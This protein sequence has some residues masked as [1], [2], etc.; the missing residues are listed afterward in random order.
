MI[1]NNYTRIKT[2]AHVFV[3][4]SRGGLWISVLTAPTLA[5]PATVLAINNNGPID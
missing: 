5:A 3:R 4:P 2:G 1:P